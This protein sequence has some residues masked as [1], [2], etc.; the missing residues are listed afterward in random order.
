MENRG[1]SQ[2]LEPFNRE[3]YEKNDKKKG[4]VTKN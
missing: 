4:K 2:I 3:S 1:G